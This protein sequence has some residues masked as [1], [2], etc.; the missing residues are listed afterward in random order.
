MKPSGTNPTHGSCHLPDP[1]T[2]NRSYHNLLPEQWIELT[3]LNQMGCLSDTGALVVRTGK[4]TGRAPKDRFIV[5]D[6]VT[7]NTVDWN[8]INK[9]FDPSHFDRLEKDMRTYAKERSLYIKDGYVC[10]NPRYRTNVR[11]IAQYPWSALFAHNMFLRPTPE[12]LQDFQPDWEILCLP[13]FEADSAVHGTPRGNF[14]IINFSKRRILIGGSAYTGEIKKSVFSALNFILPLQHK[15]LSMHCSATVGENGDV[16]IYFGLSGTGKTTLSADPN[17]YLIGDDEHGWSDE[18]VFNFEGG[19]Y[20][21]VIHLDPEKEPSIYQAIRHGALLENVVF[22]P[23]SRTPDYD[24]SAITE[25]TRVSYPI[26]FIPRIAKDLQG[27]HPKHIFF[28]TADAFGVLPPIAKL[29]PAQ[30]MYYFISG[31]TAKVAGTEQGIDEPQATFSACFG[32][33]FMPLHPTV[34]ARMLRERIQKHHTR[35]WLVNTG[36]IQGPYGK[37]KRID[38]PYTRA[39][40]NAALDGTL[41]KVPYEKLEIFQLDIPTSC[42]GVPDHI[43]HPMR[44]WD[45]ASDYYAQANKLAE[46]FVENFR[47]YEALADREVLEAAPKPVVSKNSHV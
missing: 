12:E 6:E 4:F 7:Q 32:A 35:V 21:K 43:L 45:S 34:Y 17:R 46:K 47:K 38:L 23:N 1:S 13:E 40:I 37:G 18:G 14:T 29:T 31:Y 2:T 28:L 42:P 11:L 3:I 26:H 20:A 5:R 16:A 39:L 9:P 22:K 36:W 25:N 15:V 30:A 10:A 41:D 8:D 33:P 27:G 19:C 44:S 24:N